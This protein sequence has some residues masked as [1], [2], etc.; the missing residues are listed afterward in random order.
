MYAAPKSPNVYCKRGKQRMW[1]FSGKYGSLHIPLI[2]V[3]EAGGYLYP[4]LDAPR[5]YNT[6]MFVCLF[7]YKLLT[8]ATME[9]ASFECVAAFN[10]KCDTNIC[11]PSQT[12]RD[13]EQQQQQMSA[14]ATSSTASLTQKKGPRIWL[15]ND[16]CTRI[17]LTRSDE[18]RRQRERRRRTVS[19]SGSAQDN[20][21]SA[22]L[23]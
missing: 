5:H 20:F 16:K 9:I 14:W 12:A 1:N 19:R 23:G 2:Y 11:Y 7:F 4:D 17:L 13:A 3:H 21:H 6:I 10:S 8:F 22:I 18:S 15:E